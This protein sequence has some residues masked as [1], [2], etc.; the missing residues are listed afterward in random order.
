MT[1]PTTAGDQ[2][3]P[4]TPADAEAVTALLAAAF[5]GDEMWGPW[6]FP[7]P[8]DRL[9]KRTAVFRILVDGALRFPSS[10]VSEVEG[11][12]VAAS[13]WFPPGAR[14][15]TAEQEAAL[16]TLLEAVAPQS[17]DRLVAGFGL[18]E[19]ARPREPHHYLTL[20][21]SAPAL[22]GRG[23]GSR[24]LRHTLAQVDATGRPAYLEAADHLVPMYERFGF[25]LVES[26]RLPHGPQVNGMWRAAVPARPILR[27]AY[28][29]GRSGSGL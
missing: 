12:V 10:W 7:E 2:P 15:L 18:I 21:G 5:D 1:A 23:I 8:V 20:L 13:L 4:A 22:A 16:D 29:H 14:E 25:E 17:L 3:R 24:L 9:G 26:F 6:A 19:A 11:Q 28:S 27:N